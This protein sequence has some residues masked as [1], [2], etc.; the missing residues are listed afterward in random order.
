MPERLLRK[1]VVAIA[2][3]A[4]LIAFFQFR[5]QSA[6]IFLRPGLKSLLV[7][8]L[9]I[10]IFV[11]FILPF[12]KNLRI[13]SLMLGIRVIVTLTLGYYFRD[14]FGLK[15]TLYAT[16][17][18][19]IGF[20]LPFWQGIISTVVLA[21]VG[22][23]VQKPIVTVYGMNI[24]FYFWYEHLA[25]LFYAAMIIIITVLLRYQQE[26]QVS[27][28]ELN[29]RLD[30]ATL[31]LAQT[32]MKLQE[33]AITAEQEA[34]LNE[35]KRLAREIHDT[36]AYTLTNLVM[37]MEA[38]IDLS[39]NNS[40]GLT[41]QL[42]AARDQAKDGLAEVRRALQA[43]RP[44]Q[45][46]DLNGLLAIHRL[47]KAFEKATQITV[48]LETADAPLCFGSDETNLAIFRLVQEGMTN[49]LRHGRATHISVMLN[50]VKDGLGVKIADNGIGCESSVNA[51]T[52]YGLVGMRERLEQ[53]GGYLEVHSK[54]GEGFLL[55]AWIPLSEG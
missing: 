9:I 7:S 54:P 46:T 1:I 26:N 23:L 6:V 22:V 21:V 19:E 49:A 11:V 18:L 31:A 42:E 8:C 14:Y 41:K 52:G 2:V 43:L 45:F 30:E 12:C 25:F 39:V 15:M 51:D 5:Y 32:N 53:F 28:E 48:E 36:L 37:M 40:P 55:S 4:H 16:L 44:L 20:Y 29:R 13:F 17:L 33:Y 35:R 47:V 27:T 24:P 10:S 50:R 34:M 38:A 3:L